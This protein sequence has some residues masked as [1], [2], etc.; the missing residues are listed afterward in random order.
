M[1][2]KTIAIALLSVTLATPAFAGSSVTNTWTNRNSR[3]TG[4]VTS[5]V[6]RIVNGTQVNDSQALK[7]VAD[8]G[9]VNE[10]FVRFDGTQFTGFASSSNR[11]PADPVAKGSYTRQHETLNIS[12]TTNVTAFERYDFNER[13]NSHEVTADSF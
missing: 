7:Q 11:R 5:D 9:T 8:L 3:G 10:A 6:T 2:F 4:K 1:N 12:E 13:M